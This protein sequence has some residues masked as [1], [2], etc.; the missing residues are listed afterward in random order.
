MK[1]C[2]N[3]NCKRE[4]TRRGLGVAVMDGLLQLVTYY[5]WGISEQRLVAV[6]LELRIVRIVG[7][8][9][10]MAMMMELLLR[11]VLGIVEAMRGVR[12]L[13]QLQLLLL[14]GATQRVV[15]HLIERYGTSAN[16][17]LAVLAIRT[18][19]QGRCTDHG[20]MRWTH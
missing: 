14:Y 9:G 19:Q 12:M 20:L 17:R 5:W 2:E 7:S 4:K 13:L 3:A 18:C 6:A 15:G 8:T 11:L 16:L 1:I 10:M